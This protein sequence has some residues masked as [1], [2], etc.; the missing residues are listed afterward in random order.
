ML[1]LPPTHSPFEV[2]AYRLLLLYYRVATILAG[3]CISS[4]PE[5]SFDQHLP[6]F[7]RIISQCIELYNFSHPNGERHPKGHHDPEPTSPNSVSDM[8]W[9]A[10]LYFTAIKCRNHRIRHQAVELLQ[11]TPHK[12]GI[13]SANLAITV[14]R[15]VTE[16]EE[17][18][19]YD[20]LKDHPSDKLAVPAG[21]D[22]N[23]LTLPAEFRLSNI[24]VGLP[25]DRAGKLLLRCC[26]KQQSGRTKWISTAYDLP[27]GQWSDMADIVCSMSTR[28]VLT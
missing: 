23:T 16:I 11:L 3:T 25:D 18:T 1:A 24:S 22:L 9:I 17:A 28:N 5:T 21:E 7:L 4:S 12:E 20:H 19:F 2:F 15:K 27:S 14:A 8:G 10:P 6:V 13:F 26:R